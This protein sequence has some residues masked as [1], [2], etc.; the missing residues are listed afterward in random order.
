MVGAMV[1]IAI[2][3]VWYGASQS[4]RS[5]RAAQSGMDAPKAQAK[6]VVLDP[7]NDS[8]EMGTASLTPVDGKT[9]VI[10][11]LSGAPKDMSQPAHIHT[12]TCAAIGAVKYPL[13]FPKNGE[14]ETVLDISLD[15]LLDE[16]PL[17]VN[18]HKSP[19]EAGIYY[20]C[21]NIVK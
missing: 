14:S 1:L 21:G 17:A 3:A 19:Q 13:T 11:K 10:L 12:G 6:V 15:R 7:Q 4:F 18:V 16:L 2:I 5:E 20:S 8:G 9:K